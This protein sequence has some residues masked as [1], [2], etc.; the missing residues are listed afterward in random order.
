MNQTQTIQMKEISEVRNLVVQAS[1]ERPVPE[2]AAQDARD[3]MQVMYQ[4][5]PNM[6]DQGRRSPGDTP[7]G[8]GEPKKLWLSHLQVPAKPTGPG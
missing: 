7:A 8:A 4:E 6:G 2:E 5:P 1:W 3:T